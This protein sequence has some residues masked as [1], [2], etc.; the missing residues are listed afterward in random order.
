MLNL[1]VNFMKTRYLFLS[2]LLLTAAQG[3]SPVAITSPA[4]GDFVSGDVTITGATDV[5]GFTS[6]QL[7]FSYA[8]D[9]TDTWFAL[10]TSSQPVVDS[11]LA[12]WDTSLITDGEY[13][14]RLRV[15][16]DDGSFEEVIVPVKVQNDSPILLPTPFVTATLNPLDSQI[17]TP[18]LVAASP[19]P[20]LTPRPTPTPLP[21][22]AAALSQTTIYTSLGRGALVIIGLFVF[23]GLILRF[24]RY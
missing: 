3:T 4:P 6:S 23:A 10:Q 22:N 8:S 12:I 19:T 11:P 16:V 1:S 9:S 13:I 18:F 5:L 14:L 24:R 17:P 15:F 21:T 2:V 20:T 7:D